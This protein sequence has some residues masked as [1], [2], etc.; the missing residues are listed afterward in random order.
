[1][2]KVGYNISIAIFYNF[3]SCFI[4]IYSKTN[5]LPM[6]E[7]VGCGTP[8]WLWEVV[9]SRHGRSNIVRRVYHPTRKL[10]RFSL[11]K[12]PSIPNSKFGTMSSSWGSVSYRPS[13]S[14]SYE[15]SS[16]VNNYAYSGKLLLLLLLC[17]HRLSNDGTDHVDQ[18]VFLITVSY[19]HL[20]CG[21][22]L[23]LILRYIP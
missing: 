2:Y 6:A 7:R 3:K 5:R 20:S 1:M 9:G 18:G 4:Y 21:D 16:H 11:L 19:L 15:A 23:S 10:V 13:A 14:S 22:N 12:C 8:C 17:L